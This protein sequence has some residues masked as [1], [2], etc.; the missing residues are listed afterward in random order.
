MHKTPIR[1][2]SSLVVAV[3]TVGLMVGAVGTLSASAKKAPK[4]KLTASPSKSL[5]NNAS[6]S[7]SGTHFVAGDQ[8]YVLQCVIGDTSPTGGGCDLNHINGPYTVT[9]T[10][11]IGPVSVTVHTGAIGTDGG[12]CGT[13]KK[14]FKKCDISA[15]TSGGTDTA[16]AKI[17]F[18]K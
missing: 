15:G 12:T 14:D 8:I 2:L 9:P 5:T 16:T 4:P 17:Q 18:V 3:L 6:V 10:G 1:R 7:V 13:T 11:T